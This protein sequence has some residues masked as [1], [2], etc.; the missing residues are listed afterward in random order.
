MENLV[1]FSRSNAAAGLLEL[2]GQV[3]AVSG[4]RDAA[5]RE[6]DEQVAQRTQVAEQLR[7]MREQNELLQAQIEALQAES[8]FKVTVGEA[9]NRVRGQLS[10]KLD[11]WLT[12]LGE[13]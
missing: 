12:S 9:V 13:E 4:E 10:D 1:A 8:K 6:R 7:S 11:S 2:K 3:N 5:L